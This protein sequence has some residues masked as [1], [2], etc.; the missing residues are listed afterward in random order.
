MRQSKSQHI[1]AV[2]RIL[3]WDNESGIGRYG[4]FAEGVAGRCGVGVQAMDRVDDTAE[5]DA[6]VDVS[7][8]RADRAQK[9]RSNMAGVGVCV[10]PE[11]RLLSAYPFTETSHCDVHGAPLSIALAGDCRRLADGPERGYLR[12]LDNFALRCPTVHR[13]QSHGEFQWASALP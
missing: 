4:R 11:S 3:L 5:H 10:E 8:D 9:G 1:G 12:G 6:V 7:I 2:T 13:A